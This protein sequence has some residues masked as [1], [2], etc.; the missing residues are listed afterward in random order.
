[1]SGILL[2]SNSPILS[3]VQKCKTMI[4][5]KK[6]QTHIIT[7]GLARFTFITSKILAFCALSH[8]GDIDCAQTIFNQI[9]IPNAFNFNSMILGLSQNSHPQK[10]LSLFARMRSIGIRPNSHTFR[11]LIKCCVCLSSLDQVHGQILKFGHMSDYYITGAVVNMYSKCEAMELAGQ[12][13]D[14]SI[15]LNVVCWT[16]L[17][18]GCCSNGLMNEAGKMF[19]AMPERNEISCRAMVSGYVWNGH[20]NEAIELFQELK[21]CSSLKFS[22]SLLVSV[23]SACAAIG[24]FE[25]GKWIHSYVDGNS[26]DYELEM[27]AALIDFYA[28]C[29]T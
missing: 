6:I 11:S 1:M 25:D 27:G 5:L 15:D 3:L 24:A 10:G 9:L 18:S 19:D 4:E 12:V 2:I 29:V 23:L 13:F 26:L 22:G 16:S 21:S 8:N 14:E 28:E 7:N 17:A 20:F